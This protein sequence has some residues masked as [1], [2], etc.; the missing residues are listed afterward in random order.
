MAV[1]ILAIPI[2]IGL[3]IAGY[4]AFAID[5]RYAI[6]MVP[7]LIL[8]AIL[9]VLS[10]QINW[11]WYQRYPPDVAAPIRQFLFQYPFYQRLPEG[12]KKRFRN[13]MALFVMGNNF[14]PQI[15][16]KVPEDV[17]FM[18]AANAVT[19]LFGQDKLLFPRFENIIINPKPLPTLQY[20]EKYHASEIYEP[21]GV[22]LFSMEQLVRGFLESNRY[23]NIGLYEY[24]KVFRISYPQHVYP[25]FDENIW[26]TLERISGFS[27]EWIEQWINL[28]D[29]DPVAVSIAH[30]FTF[31][32]P[33]LQELPEAY[34]K[35]RAIFKM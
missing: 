18:V 31:P 14:I 12:E 3:F 23:F 32:E 1:R 24:A 33:F 35:Y 7:P 4:L 11:W 10:P 17:K 16:E 19:F 6:W 9:W 26:E 8:L 2:V 21:D 25:R 29:I 20:P 22:V 13:R 34:K 15:I 28:P 30:F 27:K 5:G